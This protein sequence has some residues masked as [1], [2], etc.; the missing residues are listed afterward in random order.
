[1]GSCPAVSKPQVR[2]DADVAAAL[3]QSADRAGTSLNTQANQWLRRSLGLVPV[4]ATAP[5]SA[6]SPASSLTPPRSNVCAHPAGMRVGGV[7]M[8][9]HKPVGLRA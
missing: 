2:L 5:A 3:Q 7:C 1:M 9:C 8:A 4:A 6:S